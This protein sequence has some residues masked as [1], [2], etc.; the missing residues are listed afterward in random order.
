MKRHFDSFEEFYHYYLTQHQNRLSR[1]LHLIGTLGGVASFLAGLATARYGWLVAAFVFGY[2]C[3]WIGHFVF[4]KNKPATFGYPF[5]SF[6]SDFR[7][8]LDTLLGRW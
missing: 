5:Y 2:G 3:G 1:F 7:M 8:A 4:E 6:I